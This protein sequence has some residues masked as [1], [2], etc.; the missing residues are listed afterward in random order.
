MTQRFWLGTLS[1][2]YVGHG[3]TYQHPEDILWW[4]KGGVLH[5]ESPQRIQWLKD[6]MAQAPPFHEL[7][8]LGDD[9]GRFL[10]AKPGEYY[11]VYCVGP[12]GRRPSSLAGDRPYKVD[13]DRPV[14]DDRHARRHRPAGEF[15]AAPPKTGPRTSLHTL[16]ARRETAAR[17]EDR[18]FGHRG[19]AAAD[20]AV[21][22]CRRTAVHGGIS[23]TARPATSRAPRTFS[24]SPGFT[25]SRSP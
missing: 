21:R 18:R 15:T 8:P 10:L 12:R 24:R 1:G 20:G 7:Q 13:A 19:R 6:F 22:Q 25:P 9:K 5:G 11:L 3:E 4:S 23:A 17:G 2:C 14:G 16:P